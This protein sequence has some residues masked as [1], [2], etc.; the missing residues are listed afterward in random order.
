MVIAAC[1][2]CGLGDTPEERKKDDGMESRQTHFRLRVSRVHG[3]LSARRRRTR[4][5]CEPTENARANKRSDAFAE[6]L[7]RITDEGG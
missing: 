1:T 7:F 6:A 2:V 4:D 3:L 5:W